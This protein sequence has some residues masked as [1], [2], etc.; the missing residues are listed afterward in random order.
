MEWKTYSKTPVLWYTR[1]TTSNDETKQDTTY[2]Y[3]KGGMPLVV[4]YI[5]YKE[6]MERAAKH[7]QTEALYARELYE[8]KKQ[9]NDVLKATEKAKE[10]AA[11]V[12]KKVKFAPEIDDSHFSKKVYHRQRKQKLRM[13]LL[14]LLPLRQKRRGEKAK[15][16]KKRHGE[17]KKQHEK[18]KKQ[19]GKKKKHGKRKKSMNVMLQ[20]RKK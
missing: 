2:V 9:L 15:H 11:I 7:A 12:K 6:A 13:V 18:K 16:Q 4:S 10:N 1:K 20:K 3:T 19:H 5:E 8:L 14:A 17:K